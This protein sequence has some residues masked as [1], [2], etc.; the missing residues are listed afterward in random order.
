MP[1]IELHFLMRKSREIAAREEHQPLAFM[2]MPDGR[3]ETAAFAVD[4]Y[5][6]MNALRA[7][8]AQHSVKEI[9]FVNEGWLAPM[10]DGIIPSKHPKK[11]EVL[12]L[13][14]ETQSS[15]DTYVAMIVSD[16]DKR[17]VGE[18]QKSKE[19]P[20]GEMTRILPRYNLEKS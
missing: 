19:T 3:L 4:K 8:C 6:A 2:L 13:Y 9:V 14:Y 20:E 15:R 11:Q 10:A 5:T 16:G 17:I 12:V 18:Y 7:Y 1:A